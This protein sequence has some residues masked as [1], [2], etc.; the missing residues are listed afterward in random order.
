LLG[1]VGRFFWTETVAA[2]AKEES[3]TT[4]RHT[5]TAL[6]KPIKTTNYPGIR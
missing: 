5:K 4:A 6:L 3:K 2:P 1:K